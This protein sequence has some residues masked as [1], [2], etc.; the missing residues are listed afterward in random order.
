MLTSMSTEIRTLI[1]TS[2]ETRPSR[3]YRKGDSL[4]KKD[5]ENGSIIRSTAKAFLTGTR[6]Q[7]KNLVEQVATTR[8]SHETS[9][10]DGRN[11]VDRMLPKA[12]P[13]IEGVWEIAVALATVASRFNRRV[14]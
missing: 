3:S 10:A 11:R 7:Q 8:S 6:E 12:E 5:R 14:I 4:I 2:T 9:F 1:E 13:E